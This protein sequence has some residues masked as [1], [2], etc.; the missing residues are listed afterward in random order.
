MTT[1][2]IDPVTA[3]EPVGNAGCLGSD[4]RGTQEP[5]AIRDQRLRAG[6]PRRLTV[7]LGAPPPP[8]TPGRTSS[9]VM[10][11]TDMLAPTPVKWLYCF[12]CEETFELAGS[13]ASCGC[14][15][16]SARMDGGIV[17]VQGPTRALAPVETVIRLDGG[18]WAPL[19]EDVF[20]RRVLP[21][22][23]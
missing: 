6:G 2:G 8:C 3:A 13:H 11:M 16:S 21:T 10:A 18:E 12:A 23:A 9:E 22:A 1:L 4:R 17:E 19:P 5:D 15:R 20:I 14:G 7:R